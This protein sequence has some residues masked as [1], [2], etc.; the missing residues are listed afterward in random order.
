[1]WSDNLSDLIAPLDEKGQFC[2]YEVREMG[3]EKAIRSGRE[4]RLPYRGWKAVD[5]T[6]RNHGGCGCCLKN[7]LYRTTKQLEKCAFSLKDA[8]AQEE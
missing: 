7:R 4:H 1:M 6:C 8:A 2:V 5:P 3:M